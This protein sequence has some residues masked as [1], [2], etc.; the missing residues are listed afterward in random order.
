MIANTL[1][2]NG[3]S[4]NSEKYK[5]Y[6]CD[7]CCNVIADTFF[8]VTFFRQQRSHFISFPLAVNRNVNVILLTCRHRSV[9]AYHSK[10]S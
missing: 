4:N 5:C 6:I 3:Y 1:W 10:K 9:S 2:Q 7:D 8:D